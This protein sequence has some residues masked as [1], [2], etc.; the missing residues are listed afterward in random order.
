MDEG[1]RSS[2]L[3]RVGPPF[4]INTAKI[5]HNTTPAMELD[6]RAN[7][8]IGCGIIPTVIAKEHAKQKFGGWMVPNMNFHPFLPPQPGWPGLML[9]LGGRLE[10]WTPDEGTEFR[11]VVKKEPCFVEYLGQYEM[12]RL[13]DITGDEWKRQP[14]KVVISVCAEPISGS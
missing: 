1:R 7:Y 8:G 14:A 11:V 3:D 6:L 2:F 9:R 12:V 4:H 5:T 10:E 13:S